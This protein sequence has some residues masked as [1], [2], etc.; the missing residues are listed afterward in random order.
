MDIDYEYFWSLSEGTVSLAMFSCI[1][2]NKHGIALLDTDAT[3]NY[4][5]RAYAKQIG[6]SINSSPI[7]VVN[8]P[9]GQVMRVYGIVEFEMDISEWRGKITIMILDM[10]A[11]FDVVLGMEWILEWDSRSDWKKL[12]FIIESFTGMKRIRRLSIMPEVQVL[13]NLIIDELKIEFNLIDEKELK[14]VLKK[15]GEA[16][17]VLYFAREEE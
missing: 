11:I 16:E 14:K 7:D 5:S 2:R 6:L 12:E 13:A 15:K 9:N 8:L 4:I 10:H 17:C 3:R 1:I